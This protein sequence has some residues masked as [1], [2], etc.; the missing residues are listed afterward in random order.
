M[1]WPSLSAWHF[2]LAGVVCATIPFVIHLLNRRRFRV[3]EWAAMDFLR[4]ALE[5]NRRIL[6]LR[7]LL[8]LV[9]RTAAVLL[10][11]MALARPYLA[12]SSETFD[13]SQPLHAVLVIDNSLSM[14]YQVDNER[15]LDRGLERARSFVEKL[16]RGSR[17]SVIP[18]CGSPLVST[19]DPFD[20][21]ESALDAI[22]RIE[23]VD[24]SA[25]I[26]RALNEA[27]RACETLPD[28]A[29][30]VVLIGD[31]Q[32]TTWRDFPNSVNWEGLPPIQVV[33]LSPPEWENSWI[34][35]LRLQDGLAD[36]ET[37][38]TF[39][40]EIEHRGG[41]SRK[42]VQVTLRV[43]NAVIGSKTVSLEPS[44]GARQVTFEHQF[45]RA[46]PEPGR[47]EF[48]SVSASLSPDRLPIDDERFMVVPVVAALPVVFVD[49]YAPQD[50]DPLRQRLGETRHLR[51]LLAPVTSRSVAER[52]LVAIRHVRIG[53]LNRELLAD[54][55]LVVIAGIDRPGTAVP[56][57]REYV[58]QGGQLVIAAGAAFDPAAW[59]SDAWLD[60]EGIL[61][62][63]LR[64]QLLGALP[65]EA[66]ERIQPFFIAYDSMSANDY[67]QLPDT[68]ADELRD[69][70]EQAFFFQAVDVDDTEAIT[71]AVRESEARR[72][73]AQVNGVAEALARQGDSSRKQ[74]GLTG[75]PVV[76]EFSQFIPHWVLWSEPVDPV[77]LA[78]LAEEQ[79][80]NRERVESMVAQW[81]PRTLARFTRLGTPYLVERQIRQGKV[82][83]VASGLLSSWN[84]LPKTDT[85]FL[86]DRILRS[87]IQS[88]L[89]RHNFPTQ[90]RIQFPLSSEDRALAIDLRRP[91]RASQPEYH[92]V[93][94]IGT[95]QRGLTITNPLDRGLYQLAA[96]RPASE[97]SDP[98]LEPESSRNAGTSDTGGSNTSSSNTPTMQ[99]AWELSLAVNGPADE[100]DL[101]RLS[102]QRAEE[103]GSSGRIRWLNAEEEISLAGAQIRGQN[104]WWYL[105]LLVLLCLLGE[106]ATLAWTQWRHRGLASEG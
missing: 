14:G 55:R 80:A 70:Y 102:S 79:A 32:R 47:A 35:D 40:V 86:F 93:G 30:R 71:Q 97:S 62:A 98:A 22:R 69:L 56:L 73:M 100:S 59:T 27:K 75:T 63:P 7:D 15:L 74:P 1:L 57:L 101:A 26:Q 36:T 10:F 76:E 82:L 34:S 84:T 25:S 43:D 105:V 42:D 65:E 104:L 72:L 103:L 17:V 33:D 90:E 88:T 24:R 66:G 16:P 20:T 89:P 9:L 38:A 53:D 68:S 44:E 3:V 45:S 21:K 37:A 60:G 67:F 31:Q 19:G 39:I 81:M 58:E 52:Q 8:L 96:L 51:K 12:G 48:V 92:D 23:V 54:A 18:V 85:M 50:E 61:P 6:H 46:H 106:L 77:A 83:F 2:A 91:G 87:M 94:F 13:G 78:S 28:M 64:S 29:K 4:Q 49:Q 95:Q 99:T 41:E 5:R 11:G